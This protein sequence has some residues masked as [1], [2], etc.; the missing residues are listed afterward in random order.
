MC[1][2]LST[3]HLRKNH[4]GNSK[5]GLCRE[6]TASWEAIDIDGSIGQLPIS[7]LFVAQIGGPLSAINPRHSLYWRWLL[8]F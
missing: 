7:R 1:V 3:G 8:I 4:E 5:Q 2:Y 6:K